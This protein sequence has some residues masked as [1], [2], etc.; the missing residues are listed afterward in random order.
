[1]IFIICRGPIDSCYVHLSVAAA[2]IN[3]MPRKR[4]QGHR[5]LVPCCPVSCQMG[6]RKCL[7]HSTRTNVAEVTGVARPATKQ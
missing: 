6:T 1:M 3:P 2:K 4:T 7:W 5:T